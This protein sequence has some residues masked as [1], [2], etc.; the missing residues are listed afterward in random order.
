M[1]AVAALMMN[2]Y[3][4]MANN[5]A[6]RGMMANNARLNMLSGLNGQHLNHNQLAALNAMDTQLEIDSLNSSLGYKC[7]KKMLEQL[8]KLQ[9]DD[10]KRSFSI[11]A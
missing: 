10:I 1:F 7:S 2:N 4:M 9:E 8:K 3:T 5:L 11:F 6:F